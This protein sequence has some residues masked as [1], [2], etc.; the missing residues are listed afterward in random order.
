MQQRSA[1]AATAADLTVDCCC[2]Q[3]EPGAPA[4]LA[5]VGMTNSTD[6]EMRQ[7]SGAWVAAKATGVTQYGCV[8]TVPSTFELGPFDVR[9][10]GG[11]AFT[12][13]AARP[14]F[15]FGDGGSFSTPGGWVR[16]VGDA[17]GL[18]PLS[19]SGILRLTPAGSSLAAAAPVDIKARADKSGGG[20]G[21]KPTRW[22][23][24]FDLP[25]SIAAGQYSVAVSNGAGHPPIFTPLCTF[26]DPATPC[27]S[28]LNV[29]APLALPA[30]PDIFTVNATQPGVGRDASEAVAQAIAAATQNGGGVVFFPRGQYFIK[31]ALVVS[32]G[33]VLRGEGRELV[34]IYFHEANATTAP[35]AYVTST[36]AGSWG[37]EDLTFYVTAFANDIVR[38]QPGTDGAFLRR[39]R[40]RF[41]SYFCLEP[42]M[43][44]GSRGRNTA[45]LHSIGTAVKL[46]GRNLFVTD[47]DIF[48]SG[49]VVSTLNNGAAG[50]EYMHIARNR[51]WN[52][53][54][55]HWGVSWKQCIYEDNEATGASTT[56]MGSN[57][58]QYAHNDGAPHIQN[59]YHHNNTQNMVW[60][61][62]REMMTCDGGGGVYFGGATSVGTAVSLANAA[63]G[64]QPGGAMCVLAGTG[65]GECRRVVS[66][67]AGP[68]PPPPPPGPTSP[69]AAN[70]A[71]VLVPCADT[72]ALRF[73]DLPAGGGELREGKLAACVLC[74][75]PGKGSS[76]IRCGENPYFEPVVFNAPD[77][78]T[79]QFGTTNFTL[80]GAELKLVK[81]GGKCLGAA[82][83][84]PVAGD[85]LGMC[86]CAA[87]S[88]SA[89]WAYTGGKFALHNPAVDDAQPQLCMGY[90]AAAPGP[91]P[92]SKLTSFTVD[93]AFTV[94]LDRTSKVSITP[95]IG[96]IAFNGNY[97]SDGGEIQFYAQAFG[98]TASE[99]K[100][101]RTGGLSAW[102]RGYSGK[103]A[104]LRNS[105]VDN[106]V[107]E[108]NHVWNC[109]RRDLCALVPTD[110]FSSR[111]RRQH[112][113]P[114]VARR[115]P[116][117]PWRQ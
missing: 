113:R 14:W 106:E 51:L 77:S 24:L 53:G 98:I 1:W 59:V 69:L 38:F 76:S 4:L 109:E 8:V 36:T 61:N 114:C 93:R 72:R 28:T 101:E 117:L 56:A 111:V 55:T 31:Q 91:P 85:A 46:A 34:S 12:A 26:I 39:T 104:N 110:G 90:S 65:T 9:A 64:A 105:F 21:A 83:T 25:P 20:M 100:F 23:A 70:S 47:N 6:I 13:N 58:P 107:V 27:L 87:A 15:H 71:A 99:N 57:Y 50:A 32:P 97:Y 96:Q 16:I 17:I 42:A 92:G 89:Q 44:Q 29:S 52:G 30:R 19:A 41:N 81:G 112:K 79:Q 73:G 86:S 40:I 95:Y 18:A 63:S 43:G 62:D 45:W 35:P 49:D 84:K 108:G 60:G 103:D 2:K 11:A 66:A 33:T 7:G 116:V 54:T 94:P 3:V 88:A 37:A 5:V 75:P 115:V 80:S 48:S 67:R 68:P 102:A 78:W 74:D 82:T 10:G 22:H